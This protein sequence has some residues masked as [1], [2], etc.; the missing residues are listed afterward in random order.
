MQ[1]EPIHQNDST[2]T[3]QTG[4]ESTSTKSDSIITH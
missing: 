4:S 3:K 1:T 2:E